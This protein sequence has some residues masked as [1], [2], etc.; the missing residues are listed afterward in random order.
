[1]GRLRFRESGSRARAARLA[2]VAGLIGWLAG[3]IPAGAQRVAPVSLLQEAQTAEAAFDIDSAIDRLYALELEYP[4]SGD[5]VAGRMQLARLLALAGD[6]PSAVLQ[7]QT[8]RDELPADRPERQRALEFASILGRRLLARTRP[9]V[10]PVIEAVSTKGLSGLDEPTAVI[11]ERSGSW[12]IVDQGR[13]RIY[14]ISEEAAVPLTGVQEPQAAAI[15]PDGSLVLG[16]RNG[17][18][19][20]QGSGPAP[21]TGTWGGRSR[22]LRRPRAMDANSRGDLFLIDR[23][24]DGLLRCPA[25]AAACEPWGPPGRL[26]TVK[27]GPSDLVAT[28]DERQ[29]V[30]VLDRG[31]KLLATAGPAVGSTKFQRLADIAIDAAYGLYLLDQELR[32][33]EVL[34]LVVSPDG[35]VAAEPV[36][37]IAIAAEGDRALR[38]PSALAVTAA[39]AVIVAGESSPRLLRIQ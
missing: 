32:Q 39:G 9:G 17:L 20:T 11:Q 6:L 7:C 22:P 3:P 5:A 10:A 34:A 12:L 14:R 2:L 33:I 16:G 15:L 26:R 4:R 25:A 28:L 23:D 19:V 8:L 35:H 31:G 21:Q 38:D 13:D 24:Y 37:T 30:R 27:V 1:M 18:A 29:V 36:R